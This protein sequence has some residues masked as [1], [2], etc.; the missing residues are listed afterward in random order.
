MSERSA[1]GATF[2]GSEDRYRANQNP[3]AFGRASVLW[4]A[5]D[6]SSDL[7]CVKVFRGADTPTDR[8]EEF[9]NEMVARQTLDHRHIL[10]ILDYGHRSD[11]DE[12][13]RPFI[14]LPYCKGG[15]LR[16]MLRGR[17][18]VSP[19]VFLPILEQ[20]ALAVDFAHANG[21]IHG[22]IKPENVLFLDEKRSHACLAD[23]GIATFFP[24]REEITTQVG[25]GARRGG[26]SGAGSTAYLSPEQIGFNEQSPSSDIYALA[27]VAYEVLTG[28]LPFDT[29]APPFRQMQAK[30]R[31]EIIH[32]Q[33]A[34]VRLSKPI[35]DGLTAGLSNKP[36]ERPRSAKELC[37]LLRGE[38]GIPDSSSGPVPESL[39]I[40]HEYLVELSKILGERFDEGELRAL[41]FHLDD[42]DYDSL[43]GE[44]KASKARELIS[45]LERRNRISE[46]IEIGEQL[47]PDIS[48]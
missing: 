31:G 7:V 2:H 15:N 46:L 5:Q 35:C 4:L 37:Q 9:V 17:D 48:W 13:S 29:S 8:L 1:F 27:T 18:F 19:E 32:P 10:P 33:T 47:R 30:V 38:Q 42:V 41:C 43:P 11:A 34:N 28:R 20:I 36:R 16:T 40:Q 45:Y 23:F 12:V 24:I 14:V 3:L 21:V 26:A 22:D 25:L 39:R 6:S 44:G